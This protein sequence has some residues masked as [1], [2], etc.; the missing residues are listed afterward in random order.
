MEIRKLTTWQEKFEADRLLA[1]AFFHDWDADK[2]EQLRRQQAENQ[3]ELNEEIWGLMDE[4]Q[5]M[6]SMIKTQQLQMYFDGTVQPFAELEMVASLP[7]LRGAGSIRSMMQVI[8]KEFRE[9]GDLFV[10]LYP[11]SFSYYRKFGFELGCRFLEQKMP[12]EHL[13]SFRCHFRPAQVLESD[14][15]QE[16]RRL[17][18]AFVSHYNLGTVKPDSEWIL[19]RNGSFGEPNFFHPELLKYTYLLSDASGKGRG[20]V[21]F[22]FRHGENGPITGDLDV[23]ELIFD[24]PRSLRELLGFL[25]TLR[26]KIIN[27]KLKLPV[28]VDL[29]S[30]IPE[31]DKVERTLAGHLML[32]ALDPAKVLSL[33]HAPE[34][35]GEFVLRIEDSFMPENTADYHVQYAH[36]RVLSVT[37]SK[38]EASQADSVLLK[39]C[40]SQGNC[41]DCMSGYDLKVTQETFSQLALGFY[42][43]SG[44]LYR[45]GTEL[46]SARDALESFFLPRDLYPC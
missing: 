43:L 44:A 16:C 20:Y 25:Y 14:Q 37:A 27:V 22:Y 18:E 10:L 40:A 24:S 26:S 6:L 41:A 2:T 3:E 46:V 7:E 17:Y 42:G 11:F 45:E 8:L 5:K 32:R 13:S 33:M 30:L 36:G 38:T 21:S 31:C 12:I 1:T 34:G 39:E 9:R 15:L 19:G 23:C 29:A 28:S 4:N 35:S